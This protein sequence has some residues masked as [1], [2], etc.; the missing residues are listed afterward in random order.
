MLYSTNVDLRTLISSR[1][2]WDE[3]STLQ[4]VDFHLESTRTTTLRITASKA[5]L[6]INGKIPKQRE[7]ARYQVLRSEGGGV[8][9]NETQ[10]YS[11]RSVA[12]EGPGKRE[13]KG[14]YQIF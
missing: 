12:K 11:E 1:S 7:P 13:R 3:G 4:A 9:K 8:Y 6:E 10:K 5:V 2:S 14:I